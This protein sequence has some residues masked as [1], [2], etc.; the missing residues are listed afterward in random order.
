MKGRPRFGWMH[1]VKMALS[2]RGISEGV[3]PLGA[4]NV[5]VWRALVN[6]NMP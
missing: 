6:V 5:K 4:K 2:S 1:G 3:E